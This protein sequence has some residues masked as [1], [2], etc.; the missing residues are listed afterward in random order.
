MQIANILLSLG[1]D[2]RNQVP[3]YDVTPAE[4]AVLRVIHGEDAVIDIEPLGEI[5][6]TNREERQRL[7]QIYSQVQPDGTRRS[8]AVDSL[9]PGVAARV[10]ESFD[11]MDD[12]PEEFFKAAT[13][14][15]A[16]RTVAKPV[17]V[18][19]PKRGKAAKVEE[20]ELL[21]P[22]GDEP[23][24]EAPASVEEPND[25]IGDIN[26]GVAEPENLFE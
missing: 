24:D 16:S 1:G 15:S 8:P 5:K 14:V 23:I 20:V 4:V 11:E 19:K 10:Y 12:L 6:R 17:T 22:E 25:G 7:A 13:R 21:D 26:D 2:N 18:P 3:K 9:F